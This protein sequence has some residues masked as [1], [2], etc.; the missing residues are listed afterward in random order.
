AGEHKDP[1]CGMMVVPGR[2]AASVVH[3]DETV[4]FCSLRCRDRFGANPEAFLDGSHHPPPGAGGS[5]APGPAP[6]KA[7]SRAT[8]TFPMHPEIRQQ[9]P[10]SCPIC[11]MALEPLLATEEEDTSELDDM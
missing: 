7:S 5:S 8:Y 10:G 4:Y 3:G 2:S 9:G 1:V 11:G 6:T